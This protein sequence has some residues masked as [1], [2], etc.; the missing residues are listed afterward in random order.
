[1]D[2]RPSATPLRRWLG[3]LALAPLPLFAQGMQIPRPSPGLMPNPAIGKPTYEQHCSSC[4]GGALQGTADKGPPLL[5]RI[6]EPS[7]H[8]DA[9]FQLAVKSGSRAHHWKFGDMAPVPGV[10]PDEVAHITAYV[11]MMQRK[12]GIH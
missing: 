6:Y 9:A 11:R 4:H 8:A 7:H 5:H 1:M 12:A 3:A 2:S 10:S